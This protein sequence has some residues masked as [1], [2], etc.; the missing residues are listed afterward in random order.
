MLP[1]IKTVLR[2]KRDEQ[3]LVIALV[4][5]QGRHRS[6]AVATMVHAWVSKAF[7]QTWEL[8]H[9]SDH[10]WGHLCGGR[11]PCT[12]CAVD[13]Q[14]CAAIALRTCVLKMDALQTQT[15]PTS[16]PTGLFYWSD[17]RGPP[18]DRVPPQISSS[19]AQLKKQRSRSPRRAQPAEGVVVDK[20]SVPDNALDSTASSLSSG[21][22]ASPLPSAP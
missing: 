4:C 15:L 9:M 20:E 10:E 21:L 11:P 6:V 3:S 22:A 18:T 13:N 5:N 16:F 1:I 2:A 8:S 7:T 17:R 19:E 14:S 12:T